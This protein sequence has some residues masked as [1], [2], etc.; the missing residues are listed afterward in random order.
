M[1]DQNAL[2]NAYNA[3]LPALKNFFEKLPKED[4]LKGIGVLVIMAVGS[5]IIDVI[6]DIVTQKKD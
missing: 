3:G 1:L 5:K 4:A 6:K 2:K